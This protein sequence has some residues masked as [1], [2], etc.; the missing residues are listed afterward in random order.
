MCASC[1]IPLVPQEV[2]KDGPN[3]GRRFWQ[4]PQGLGCLDKSFRGWVAVEEPPAAKRAR[5]FA[6]IEAAPH[7]TAAAVGAA[8]ARPP[9]L[10]DV[11]AEIRLIGMDTK[12]ILDILGRAEAKP[13]A[14][15][16]PPS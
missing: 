16:L 10:Q 6:P 8:W 11:Y 15:P 3:H 2:K 4:C 5:T 12:K 7:A 1:K 14:P 9:T 13:A